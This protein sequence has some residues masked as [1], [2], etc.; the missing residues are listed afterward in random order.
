MVDVNLG[1]GAAGRSSEAIMPQN[2]DEQDVP[3]EHPSG[4]SSLREGVLRRLNYVGKKFNILDRLFNKSTG[5]VGLQYGA[6]AD[7][8]FSN[9][10][11]KPDQNDGA[12]MQDV[13]KPPNYEEAALDMAPS[14]YG[15]DED[16]VGMYYN[17]I[18]FE[19]LPVGNVVNLLWNMIVSVSFQ[20]VGF[21]LTY[22]L[23]T[24]HAAKQGSRFGLGLTFLGYG[25]SMI[26]NDVASKVGNSKIVNKLRPSDPNE[27]DDMHLYSES[28][29]KDAFQSSLSQGIDEKKGKT[30]FLAVFLFITGICIMSK[31]IYDYVKVK[32]KEK[33]YLAQGQ[34]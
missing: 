12:E 2:S 24:S 15:M 9:L 30:P 11:A 19:G 8:V 7:G 18:C 4:P 1:S 13:D 25:Y 10:T 5:N 17:E 32:R 33:H 21:L 16:G 22:I 26:P 29:S 3:Q 27:Y 14:Y 23:H 34:V 6:N 28:S 20:F 31:S